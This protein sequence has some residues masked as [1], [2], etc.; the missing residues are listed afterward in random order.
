VT[1]RRD[2]GSPFP[3]N[4]SVTGDP[5]TAEQQ[6]GVSELE[7]TVA[8]LGAVRIATDGLGELQTGSVAVVF[9]NPLGGV[10]RFNLTPFGTA[11][12]GSSQ[13]V[14]GFITPVRR[15]AINTG[16]AVAN[17]LGE[18]I[19]VTMRLR[20]L[21]GQQVQGGLRTL[22]LAAG[23]HLAKFLDELFPNADLSNFEGTV[24]VTTGSLNGLM[25]ATALE[26]GTAAGEFTT[27]PVTPIP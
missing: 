18:Q 22:A 23:E 17:P 21:N 5:G 25:I 16:I 4:L 15:Q 8:P 27:L 11:G 19:G 20:G 14:R 24:T 26:L 6:S 13:L 12:V 1:L 10:I 7:V 2:D 3:L 9:D